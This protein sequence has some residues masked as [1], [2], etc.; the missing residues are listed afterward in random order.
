VKVACTEFLDAVGLRQ[1]WGPYRAGTSLRN[2]SIDHNRNSIHT[3]RSFMGFGTSE[4]NWR[5]VL[6]DTSGKTS[7]RMRV[8]ALSQMERPS[9]TLLRKLILDRNT[10]S[11]LMFA[12]SKSYAVAI[13]RRDLRRAAKTKEKP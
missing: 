8:Y 2:Y 13:A 4:N 10:T 1:Y 11:R 9:L 12:L 7:A 6:A 3:Q 5:R